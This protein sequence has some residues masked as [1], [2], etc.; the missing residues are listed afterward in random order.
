MKKHMLSVEKNRLEEMITTI[1]K[2]STIELNYKT[3]PVCI[4]AKKLFDKKVYETPCH[5]CRNMDIYVRCMSL[6][7]TV[8]ANLGV[9]VLAIVGKGFGSFKLRK[10]YDLI[11]INKLT[12]FL[13]II[14]SEI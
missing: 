7:E 11:F 4:E 5:F 10:G 2:D 13:E 1:R 6:S 8:H 14:Q 3:C 12:E 9:D